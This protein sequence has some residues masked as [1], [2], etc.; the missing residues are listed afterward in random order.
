MRGESEAAARVLRENSGRVK[1]APLALMI[2]A[3]Y[4]QVEIYKR[5]PVGVDF[6]CHSNGLSWASS[7]DLAY[8]NMTCP[9]SKVQMARGGG[10]NSLFK[11]S[12]NFN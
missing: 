5:P 2:M 1:R 10:V 7:R 3:L 4:R 6:T 11:F 9:N 8:A 12:T